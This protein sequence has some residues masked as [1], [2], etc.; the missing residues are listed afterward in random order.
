M[1]QDNIMLFEND[2]KSYTMVDLYLNNR[3][4]G[5]KDSYNYYDIDVDKILL[6]KKSDNEYII[7]YNDVNKM[8]IV[9]LQLKMNNSYNKINAFKKNN[10]IM[11]IYNNDK[12]FFRKC[13]EIWDRIIELIGINNHIYFL[14][15]DDH[16]KLFVMA[17]VH[18]N[19]SIVIEDNYRYGHNKV[20]IVLRSVIN[21]CIKTSLVQHRY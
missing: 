5:Y 14:K 8:I 17:D 3:F 11:L 19:T 10:K 6:F 13:I 18:K 20:V 9:P 7:R 12:G 4:L 15:A 1:D 2:D 16:D 21:D